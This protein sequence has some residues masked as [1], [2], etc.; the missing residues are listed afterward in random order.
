MLGWAVF[1]RGPG[2]ANGGQE[3]GRPEEVSLHKRCRPSVSQGGS[4]LRR[5]G[6]VPRRSPK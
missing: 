4:A 6:V 2:A 5:R 1:R 3:L